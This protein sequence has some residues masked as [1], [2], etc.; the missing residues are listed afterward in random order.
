MG[1][2]TSGRQ[3]DDLVF[4]KSSTVATSKNVSGGEQEAHLAN[5][6]KASAPKRNCNLRVIYSRTGV[7]SSDGIRGCRSKSP[8][9]V[10]HVAL[11]A[12]REITILSFRKWVWN[13]RRFEI[14]RIELS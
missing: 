4:L 3:L 2:G 5:V 8:A 6:G 11:F 13:I 10:N 14:L 1:G 12:I 9:D 7:C